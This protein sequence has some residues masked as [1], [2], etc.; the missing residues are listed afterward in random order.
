MT[1]WVLQWSVLGSESFLTL[2][3]DI[4]IE[5][6]S[7][8]LRYAHDAK[9]WHTINAPDDTSALQGDLN[10]LHQWPLEDNLLFNS[11]KGRVL[12]AHPSVSQIYFLGEFFFQDSSAE[13]DLGIITQTNLS[14]AA[15][16][17]KTASAAYPMLGLV[18]RAFDQID[19]W[20]FLLLLNAFL[21][22]YLELVIQDSS[23]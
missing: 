3:D 7:P 23:S 17:R 6:E 8:L 20:N 4:T 15:S 12:F 13:E 2:I 14:V 11:S 5:V 16:F 18:K 10:R 19:P 1:S 21:R 9:L 22:H